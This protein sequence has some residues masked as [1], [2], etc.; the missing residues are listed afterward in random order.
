MSNLLSAGFVRLRKNKVFYVALG[1]ILVY[2]VLIYISQYIE[3]QKYAEA[4]GMDYKL[5]PLFVNFMMILGITEAVFV[6]LFTG[7]E[8]SDG[9]IR[10]KLVI[11]NLR[12]TIYLS[13][14]I[15]SIV[16]GIS[17]I[18]VGY[19]A[20]VILGMPLFGTF[21]TPLPQTLFY[22]L[23][24]ILAGISYAAIFHI[25]SM[26]SSSKATSAVVCLL[27]G[28]G[29]M[30]LGAYILVSLEQPEMIEQ[31]MIKDGQQVMELVRN[32]N[33]L[34]GMK[35]EIYQFILDVLPSGQCMQTFDEE[36]LHPVRMVVSSLVMVAG[37]SGLGIYLFGKKDIK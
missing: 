8:Y 6:S 36:V 27:V 7:T 21:Q 28:F 9:T 16:A 23:I 15:V 4:Y 20:G 14:L 10:N 37:T 18:V 13:N 30:F 33:Y 11:G 29:M 24:G 1:V 2:C 26:L 12:S 32:P 19:M 31:M 5:D 35:R 3:M 17:L 34:D 25:I 22:L